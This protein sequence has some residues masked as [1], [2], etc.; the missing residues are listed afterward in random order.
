MSALPPIPASADPWRV[1]AA[2]SRLGFEIVETGNVV[3]GQFGRWTADVRYDPA[4]P[5]AAWLRVEVETASAATGEARRDALLIGADWLDAGRVRMAV[6][7]AEGFRPLGGDRF[8][9]TGTLK[10]RDGE[11]PVTLAFTLAIDGDDARASG[12]TSLVRTQYG[13]GH[14]QWAGVV[15]FDVAVVV[16]LVATRGK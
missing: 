8:E 11:R 3:R 9:T 14:G 10:L 4:D 7:E 6:F 2:R 16:E 12:R 1:D 15:G 13:I 5:A